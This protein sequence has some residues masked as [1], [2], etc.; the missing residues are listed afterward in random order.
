MTDVKHFT[1]D[2]AY[3][4]MPNGDVVTSDGEPRYMSN[5]HI[6][7]AT[8]D[9]HRPLVFRCPTPE[10]AVDFARMNNALASQFDAFRECLK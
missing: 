9:G 10:E 5:E 6:N 8:D 3:S 2:T 4:V 1:V 7:M